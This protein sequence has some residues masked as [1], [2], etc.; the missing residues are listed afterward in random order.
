VDIL[1]A[2]TLNVDFIDGAVIGP[3]VSA[4]NITTGILPVDRIGNS[5]ITTN[6]VDATFHALLGG[7]GAGTKTIANLLPIDYH[8][9]VTNWATLGERNT[10][11]VLQFSDTVEW[12][13]NWVRTIPEAAVLTS[14]LTFN[15]DWI[16]ATA[17]ADDVRWCV[18]VERMNTDLDADSFDTEACVT[19]TA[20]G[21]S[22]IITRATITITTIDSA[23]AGD[24]V[25]FRIYRDHDHADDDMS[26][27]AQMVVTEVRTAN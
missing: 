18:Q 10:I 15:I 14:G 19:S 27:L 12:S 11:N 13:A 9:P 16:A 25:R 8:Q 3:G 5:S 17:T 20:N 26:G 7:G 6:K 22:G 2:E 21:T 23:A 4:T 1:N 24:P